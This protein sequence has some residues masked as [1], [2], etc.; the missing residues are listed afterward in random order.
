MN[1]KP[2][3]RFKA[4]LFGLLSIKIG[5]T[6]FLLTGTVSVSE[7]LF[8]QQVAIAQ[9]K[10]VQDEQ[11]PA[12]GKAPVASA[13]KKTPSSSDVQAV[14]DKLSME[15][16]RLEMREARIKKEHAQLE[17]LKTELEEKIERLSKIQKQIAADL[18][19][20]EAL[21]AEEEQK[22]KAADETKIRMLSKVYA[23]MK[24]KQAAAIIDKM[25]IEVIQK[26]FSQ[27]KGE[28]VG[29][30]LSYV[31]KERAAKIS[32]RLAENMKP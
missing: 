32:E 1:D 28:Q 11:N 6:L 13:A 17:A 19:K 31:E 14:L 2:G 9:D 15:R 18:E 25:D 26:V 29:N 27:M 4:L 10:D 24:P 21:R 30:I 5:G 12:A 8:H 3:F 23:S 16:K 22:Q 7:M 20:K